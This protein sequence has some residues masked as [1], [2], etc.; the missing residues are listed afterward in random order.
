M[1]TLPIQD[2]VPSL[3]SYSLIPIGTKFGRWTVLENDLRK[4]YKS[5]NPRACRV[6]CDCEKQTIATIPYSALRS[7]HSSSCGCVK[8]RRSIETIW[9]DLYRQLRRRGWEIELTFIEFKAISQLPCAYCNKAPSNI[10]RVKYKVDGKNKRNDDPKW[11]ILYSGMD[12]VDSTRGY[13]Y[14]NVVPCCGECNQMKSALPLDK[15]FELIERIRLH[16]SPDKIRD[17][18][19]NYSS[20]GIHISSPCSVNC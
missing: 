6:C 2:V 18:A 8:G 14:G 1:N 3:Q 10:H 15:F 16:S 11:N 12:R 4:K 17:C 9:L 5:L 13:I 20:P 7:G 19:A